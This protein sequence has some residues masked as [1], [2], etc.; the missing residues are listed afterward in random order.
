[1]TETALRA[2]RALVLEDVEDDALLLVR[3]L[4]AG[5][6]EVSYERVWTRDKL[7]ESLKA[8][9]WDVVISDYSMPGFDA[10]TA[11]SV[12]RALAPDLPFI[13]VSGSAGEDLTVAAMK[14]GAQDYLMK[15]KLARLASSVERELREA[16]ERTAFRS[17]Q[18]EAE[19]AL[20]AQHEAEA[21]SIAKSRFLATMSHELRTPLNAILGFSEL[22]AEGVGGELTP[23][24]AEYVSYVLK[25]GRHLLKLVTEV[26]DL[27]KVEAGKLELSLEPTVLDEL[28]ND[29][30]Q[31]VL[32]IAQERGVR[33]NMSFAPM[34]PKVLCDPL[35]LKQILFN[36]L[37]NAIK[38]TPTGG[39]VSL[40]AAA[41]EQT[42]EIAISD[43]GKG[44][45]QEDMPRLFRAFEQIAP[46][47]EGRSHGTGLGLAL[48]QRL[49]EVHGGTLQVE[50]ELGV[51]STF[52]VRLPLNAESWSARAEGAPALQ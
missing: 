40:H 18:R 52:T 28:A 41:R 38:F 35:R 14:A 43:T 45:A 4:R 7:V 5:G 31:S 21:A 11:L 15:D 2:L 29:V 17:A 36:L 50:S 34:L 1:M 47:A 10:P 25:G 12:V 30:G 23:K 51:G 19:S 22:L 32:P 33:L 44:I 6:F 39:R 37:S 48:C 3:A 8:G 27:A 42:L 24:Q 16:R 46:T 49:V 20:R 9:P 26:L 13:I